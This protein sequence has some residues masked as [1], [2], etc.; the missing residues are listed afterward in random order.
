MSVA[1]ASSAALVAA[2]V[3]PGTSTAHLSPAVSAHPASSAPLIMESSPESSITQNFN[4]YVQSQ[5]VYGMGV[6]SL[7][8]EPLMDFNLAN[9]AKPPYYMLATAYKWGA[10]GKSIT[11]TIRQGVKFD[12]GTP[13]TAADVAFSFGLLQ[14]YADVNT[15]G[16]PITG[17]T[18]SGNTVTVSFSVPEYTNL[19]AI[20]NTYVVPQSLW[21]TVGDPGTYVDANP[22]GTGPY[23]LGTF[24][25][26]GVTLTANPGYWGGTPTIGE[27]EFPVYASN[28]TVLSALTSN[29]LDWAGNFLTGLTSAFVKPAPNTHHT[30]FAPVQTNSLEPNLNEWPTN[31][32]AVRQAISLAISRTAISTQGEA[33]LE[34]VVTT[35]TGLV[36]PA[37]KNVLAPSAAKYTLSPNANPAAAM[38]VLEAAGYKLKNG[39]FYLGNKEVTIDITDPSAYTDYAEDCALVAQELRKAHIN[40]TFVGQ[41]ATAWAADVASGKF[42]LTMHWSNTGISA[43][44]LYNDWL[45]SSLISNNSAGNFERLRNKT[46]DSQLAKL[47]G[48]TTTAGELKYLGPIE[49]WFAQNLPLIP[50]VYGAAFDEYNSA[51]FTGW[52]SATNP[53]EIGQPSAPQNEIVVLHLTPT[54]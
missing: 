51:N 52:P 4:P 38:K 2:L 48:Q 47:A 23:K 9:P 28:T 6:D 5:P 3:L 21:S 42:Q 54:S 16:L 29:Q 41:S 37:F 30:W 1:A 22:V 32:L 15:A 10:G 39:F 49:T 33:G 31:Q 19:Q 25:S 50:T 46:I 45:S 26:A 11:F 27:V 8:Y 13:M 43:Y 14:K 24:S 44:L 35:A 20:G 40:A 17:A 7:I 12:N 34:P 18:S 36:L 53:Y